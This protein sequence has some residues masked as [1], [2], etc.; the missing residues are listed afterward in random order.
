MDNQVNG[1]N[2]V[3]LSHTKQL[4]GPWFDVFAV[5]YEALIIDNRLLCS[6][7]FLEHSLADEENGEVHETDEPVARQLTIPEQQCRTLGYMFGLTSFSAPICCA[8][9]NIPNLNMPAWVELFAIIVNIAIVVCGAFLLGNNN[10][11]SDEERKNGSIGIN[12]M[13]IC[14]LWI[15]FCV[16]V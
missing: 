11:E 16:R 6:L 9:Y 3:K 1:K 15:S 2:D 14:C 12:I 8:L 5:F 7:L 4:Y 13:V 10:L